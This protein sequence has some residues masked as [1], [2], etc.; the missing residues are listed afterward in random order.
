MLHKEYRGDGQSPVVL[1]V[2]RDAFY[3]NRKSIARK[4]YAVWKKYLPL[5]AIPWVDII[6]PSYSYLMTAAAVR[7]FHSL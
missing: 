5:E 1:D 2:F 7:L 3:M 4:V 6:P